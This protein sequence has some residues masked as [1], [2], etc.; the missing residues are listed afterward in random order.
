[1]RINE[2]DNENLKD[3]NKNE[4]YSLRLRF[5]Q[6][7]RKNFQD[8]DD[9]KVDGLN[10]VEFLSKYKILINELKR[11]GLDLS[12]QEIDRALF[13]KSMQGIHIDKII[14]TDS[15]KAMEDYEYLLHHIHINEDGKEEVH[16][17]LIYDHIAN[18]FE[19]I[20]LLIKDGKIYLDD[21]EIKE[22]LFHVMKG[23]EPKQE[24]VWSDEEAEENKIKPKKMI[25]GMTLKE[26]AKEW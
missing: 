15:L 10:E 6:L 14:K 18:M 13:R 16:H 3:M 26:K 11:Y 7:W 12:T 2:I 23:L 21:K 19:Q 17:C 4:L 9:Q 8:I 25:T 1:M 5:F 22:G 24:V 20:H